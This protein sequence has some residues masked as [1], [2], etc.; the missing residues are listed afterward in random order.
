MN[1]IDFTKGPIAGDLNITWI[2]GSKSLHHRTDPPIQVH[3]YDA[4]TIILRES[5]DVSFEAPFMY[6]FFGNNRVLLVD[7]GTNANSRRFP[8]RSTVD[9]LISAWLLKYPRD[10][11]ELIVAHTHGHNDHISGDEQF[12]DRNNTT[13]VPKDVLSVQSFFNITKWPDNI[14]NYDLGTR[15]L[16]II[17]TPGHDSREISIYDPWTGFLI[18]GDLVYPGRLYVFDFPAFMVSLNRLVSYANKRPIRYVMG[19][20]IEM[21]STPMKD[22]PAMLRY[23][24]DEPP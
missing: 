24:P 22:Y 21:T 23:Q 5:K 15:V 12:L 4:H 14:G 8:L 6:L 11:Y 1:S 7:T 13:I 16:D 20:H 2:H 19:C 3:M 18:T 9:S 10:N 17:P